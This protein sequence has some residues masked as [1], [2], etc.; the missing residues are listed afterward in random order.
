MEPAPGPGRPPDYCRPSHRQRDYESR[1]R[2][3]DLGLSDAE[4]VVTRR[5]LD[6]LRDQ[7]YLLECAIED[8]GRDLADD[9]SPDSVR[10]SIDWLLQ[11]A[12]PLVATR[13]L[14]DG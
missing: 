11:A 14:G 12:R 3:A 7:V 10:R 8:V 5:A 13:M 9:D 6:E 2:S 1:R 4:L